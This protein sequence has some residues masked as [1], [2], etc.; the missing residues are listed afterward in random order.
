MGS[1]L[2]DLRKISS[3]VEKTQKD[4]AKN[5][6]AHRQLERD[7]LSEDSLDKQNKRKLESSAVVKRGERFKLFAIL[8]SFV[9]A[10]SLIFFFIK[11]VILGGS[12]SSEKVGL[13][14]DGLDTLDATS[15]EYTE[16]TIFINGFVDK[17]NKTPAKTKIPWYSGVPA[18]KKLR[19]TEVLDKKLNLS[20]MDF[21]R[22]RHNKESGV[23]QAWYEDGED[24][25]LVF[26]LIENDN[27]EY[28]IV[29][30]F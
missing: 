3:Q 5:L 25:A 7:L 2:D 9:I 16:S 23:F 13:V 22:I 10:A 30:I 17:Y 20:G 4:N 29:K 24:A 6:H 28:E 18:G 1:P 21:R 26:N 15:E 27:F 14:S 19:F 12:I 11:F 8:F